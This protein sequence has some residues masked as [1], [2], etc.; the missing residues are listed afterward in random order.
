R[1]RDGDDHA[2]RKL[3]LI[4]G[5]LLAL[6]KPSAATWSMVQDPVNAACAN[7]TTCTVTMS[8]AVTVGD[9]LVA[10][11]VN[12]ATSDFLVAGT[13]GSGT[14]VI[15]SGCHAFQAASIGISCAYILS[16][17]TSTNSIVV[18]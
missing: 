3:G 16:A 1:D 18:T 10:V 7:A 5:L 14:W 9:V 15:P 13:S 2:M 4:F 12:S 11:A 17:T 8:P 6:G